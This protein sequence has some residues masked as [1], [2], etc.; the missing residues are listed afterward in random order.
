MSATATPGTRQPMGM[1]DARRD[2]R[3][4]RR[5]RH[6]AAVHD[7]RRRSRGHHGLAAEPKRT[8]MGVLSVDLLVADD[9]RHAQVRHADH[10]R[11]QPRRRRHPRAHGARVARARRGESGCAGGSSASAS[12]ARRCSTA[13]AMI[14][15][16]VI[17]A[18]RGRGPRSDDAGAHAVHRP[19]RAGHRDR[20]VRDPEARHRGR[21]CAVRAGDVR[22]VR[23]ARRARRA[24]DRATPGVLAALN[25]TYAAPLLHRPADGGVPGARAPSCW[26]SPAPRRC[27]PTWA[28]SAPRRSAARGCWFVMPALVLNYFG[29][30]AL[31]LADPAAIKNPFYLLAP[32]WALIPLVILATAAAIIASQAVISGAFSID[33][34]GDPDGLLPAHRDP[35]HVREDDGP[36]LRPVHQL[37]AARRGAPARRRLPQLERAGRR[38]RHRGD[39]VDADRL[40]PD[41]LRHA[42]A[43]AVAAGRRARRSRCRW[44]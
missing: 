2:R 28:I 3:R 29:Q 38:L 44:R 40:D 23:R 16:A 5:H 34:R 18:G 14:T 8:C 4:L 32:S 31:L 41:L 10:A 12:S 39:D 30:G 27:T 17:G 20:A 22:L 24:A 35:A 26:P 21:R 33:A 6:V 36:D 9:H 42:A 15:P 19:G 1:L 43:V 25:P 7:A 11:R 13:T 37:D